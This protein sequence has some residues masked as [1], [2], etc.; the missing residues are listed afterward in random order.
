VGT[1]EITLIKPTRKQTME[2][3]DRNDI[4]KY[5][6]FQQAMWKLPEAKPTSS[7]VS[8]KSGDFCWGGSPFG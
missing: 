2:I 1:W 8:E 6:I 4:Y 7:Q 3:P 5:G